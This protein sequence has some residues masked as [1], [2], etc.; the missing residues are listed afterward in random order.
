MNL[1]TLHISSVICSL[2][3][4]KQTHSLKVVLLFNDFRAQNLRQV[5]VLK[6]SFETRVSRMGLGSFV[7][8]NIFVMNYYI[9]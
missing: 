1:F 7:D 9:I 5:I 2:D 4:L 8:I 3:Y 6:T